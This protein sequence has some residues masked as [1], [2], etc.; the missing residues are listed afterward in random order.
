MIRQTFWTTWMALRVTEGSC[1]EDEEESYL[2]SIMNDQMGDN[3]E[4]VDLIQETLE[5][6][7]EEEEEF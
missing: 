2:H 7:E 3:E 4:D 6:G 5:D 1:S